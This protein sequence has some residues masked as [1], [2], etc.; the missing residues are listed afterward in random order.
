MAA[1]P[2]GR[3]NFSTYFYPAPRSCFSFAVAAACCHIYSYIYI[4]MCIFFPSANIRRTKRFAWVTL[5]DACSLVSARFI[6]MLQHALTPNSVGSLVAWQQEAG[7][8]AFTIEE[9][10]KKEKNPGWGADFN[11]SI[12]ELARVSTMTRSVSGEPLTISAAT[13]HLTAKPQVS[14]FQWRGFFFEFSES[15]LSPKC[16]SFLSNWN[17]FSFIPLSQSRTHRRKWLKEHIIIPLFIFFLNIIIVTEY[18]RLRLAKPETKIWN[19]QSSTAIKPP[20]KSPNT[21]QRSFCSMVSLSLYFF[22]LN[23]FFNLLFSVFLLQGSR[24]FLKVCLVRSC[25]RTWSYLRVSA[26]VFSLLQVSS[27]HKWRS[28]SLRS[29][30][31]PFI[32]TM[33]LHCTVRYPST[34]TPQERRPCFSTKL[35]FSFSF[36]FLLVTWGQRKKVHA[37]TETL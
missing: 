5:T 31:Y 33:P 23:F 16:F 10:K 35:V 7:V 4:C 20:L 8:H 28:Y 25:W 9:W 34:F 21:Y 2:W 3:T 30:C 12:W 24:A 29:V 36:F 18:V 13:S 11:R 37:V 26:K 17:C 19:N 6:L 32:M 22:F 15:I 27:W 14:L 1:Q